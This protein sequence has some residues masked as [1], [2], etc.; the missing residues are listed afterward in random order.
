MKIGVTT[1]ILIT[2]FVVYRPI[3]KWAVTP[4]ETRAPWVERLAT[5]GTG[6]HSHYETAPLHLLG[7]DNLKIVSQ[8]N[9][10]KRHLWEIYTSGKG[11]YGLASHYSTVEGARIYTWLLVEDGKLR[12]I[13]DHTQDGGA[14]ATAV[15][16]YT[17]KGARLGFLRDYKFIEGQPGKENSTHTCL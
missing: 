2:A 9:E 13:H 3:A 12:F 15:D 14:P 11:C 10:Q 4:S 7:P 17:L 5:Y 6:F 16:T 1:A 8:S